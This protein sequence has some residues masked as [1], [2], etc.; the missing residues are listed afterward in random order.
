MLEKRHYL[1]RI[2]K[3]LAKRF[4]LGDCRLKLLQY[5]LTRISKLL[6][7]DDTK[8]AQTSFIAA[9]ALRIVGA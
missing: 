6:D 1:A 2:G 4:F 7:T 9:K 3:S 8:I 5:T